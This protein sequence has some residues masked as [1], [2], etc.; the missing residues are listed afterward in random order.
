[1]HRD[2]VIA[3]YMMANRKQ[4]ALYTGPTSDLARRVFEHREGAREGFTRRYGCK[5][6]GWF[7]VHDC[8]RAP[9][10]GNWP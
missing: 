4:G 9:F 6:L 1:M 7:E 3:T 10:R 2:G 8:W 5:R